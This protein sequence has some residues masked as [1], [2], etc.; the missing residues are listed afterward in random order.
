M[1]IWFSNSSIETSLTLDVQIGASSL[2]IADAISDLAQVLT[3]VVGADGID[4]QATVHLDGHSGIQGRDFR[5]GGA[6][7]KPA[8]RHVTRKRLRLAG[9]LYLLALQ[10]RLIRRRHHN[11]GSTCESVKRTILTA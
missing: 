1:L 4:N 11:N 7:A 2:R 9:E 10:L 8:H 3:G 6:F 5:D